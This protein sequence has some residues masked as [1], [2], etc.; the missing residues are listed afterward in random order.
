MS[1]KRPAAG[2]GAVALI[3][4]LVQWRSCGKDRM[5]KITLGSW[6]PKIIFVHFV[7]IALQRKPFEQIYVL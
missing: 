3:Y 7:C 4:S 2:G 5:H 1:P 6:L